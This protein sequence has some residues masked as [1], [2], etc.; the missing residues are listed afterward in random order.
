MMTIYEEQECTESILTISALLNCGIF[1]SDNEGH[2]LQ[3]AAFT[4]LMISLRDLLSKAEKYTQRIAFTDD[5]LT[6]NHVRDITDAVT[7]VRNACCH[8]D[9]Y[10]H[11]CDEK[12][13]RTSF[14]VVYG[15]GKFMKFGDL[16]VECE[17]DD[18]V[19]VFY[20]R[21]RL[22]L[23][24]HIVRAFREA[25]DLLAPILMGKGCSTTPDSQ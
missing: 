11:Q 7:S 5:V 20:G 22:Y 3:G 4:Q 14:V 10:E 9:S 19:A 18:D 16:E 2:I 15:K 8:L 23:K 13:N 12:G 1:K 17:Y 25:Q 21:N 6:N 24:R